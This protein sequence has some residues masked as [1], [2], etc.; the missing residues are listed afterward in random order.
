ML[1]HTY[2][3]HAHA[4]RQFAITAKTHHSFLQV[5]VYFSTENRK[6]V[7]IVSIFIDNHLATATHEGIKVSV[8]P[9]PANKPYLIKLSATAQVRLVLVVKVDAR[10]TLWDFY[11]GDRISSN[12]TLLEIDFSTTRERRMASKNTTTGIENVREDNET[13]TVS[14]MGNLRSTKDNSSLYIGLMPPVFDELLC[15]RCL[16]RAVGPCG[17]CFA[18]TNTPSAIEVNVTIGRYVTDCLSWDETTGQWTN[19]GCEVS[20]ATHNIEYS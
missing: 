17:F 12:A 4:C 3:A 19:V 6:R 13:M 10:P 2:T 11:G 7:A 8:I 15:A 1:L 14:I 5:N 20:I 16:A 18:T 9:I